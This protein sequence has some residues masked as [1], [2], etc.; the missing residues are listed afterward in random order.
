MKPKTHPGILK[1][2][3]QALGNGIVTHHEPTETNRLGQ[4]GLHTFVDDIMDV[5]AAAGL[6]G[7]WDEATQREVWRELHKYLL[8]DE[9]PWE[10][11]DHH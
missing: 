9:K 10:N 7:V 1:K 2:V 3:L 4:S 11:K 8:G 5:I 6:E